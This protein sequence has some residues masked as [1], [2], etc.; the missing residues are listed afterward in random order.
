MSI[1][2][3]WIRISSTKAY[4]ELEPRVPSRPRRIPP[5]EGHLPRPH[6]D[7]QVGG[8]VW[9]RRD[10]RRPRQP[11]ADAGVAVVQP[12]VVLGAREAAGELDHVGD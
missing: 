2:F 4:L 5:D 1:I 3:I 11:V 10:G 8:R 7:A 6:V 9:R 12:E